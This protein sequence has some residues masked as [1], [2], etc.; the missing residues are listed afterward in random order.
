MPRGQISHTSLEA[1]KRESEDQS[2]SMVGCSQ[3]G[4]TQAVPKA[5][6]I[7]LYT[8]APH[9]EERQPQRC[10]AITHMDHMDGEKAS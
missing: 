2:Q 5:L 7:T 3:R 1:S 9:T 6:G 4:S 8:E 10:L